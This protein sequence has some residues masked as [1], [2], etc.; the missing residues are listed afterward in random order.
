MIQHIVCFRFKP[1]TESGEIT[2]HMTS[3]RRLQA[4]IPQIQ[5]YAG[6]LALI[7]PGDDAPEFQAVHYLTFDNLDEMD[8]YAKQP[9]HLAFIEE[10]RAIWD[11]VFVINSPTDG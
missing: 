3:F 9:V 4:G 7:E 10:N 2:R 5:S 6:G 11:K 1:G 8:I